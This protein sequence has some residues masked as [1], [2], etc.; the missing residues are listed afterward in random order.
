MRKSLI[1]ETR[2][3][4]IEENSTVVPDGRLEFATDVMTTNWSGETQPENDSS[5]NSHNYS[6]MDKPRAPLSPQDDKHGD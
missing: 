5:K 1:E 4:F 6:D 2:D 3:D